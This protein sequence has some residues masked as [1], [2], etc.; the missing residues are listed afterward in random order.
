[1]LGRHFDRMSN[2]LLAVQRESVA[3]VHR[4][5]RPDSATNAA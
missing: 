4:A 2:L 5:R 1:M 3:L